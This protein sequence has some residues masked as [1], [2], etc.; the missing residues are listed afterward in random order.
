MAVSVSTATLNEY[1]SIAAKRE[2]AAAAITSGRDAWDIAN[3]TD[4]G[5]FENFQNRVCGP[6]Q[7]AADALIRKGIPGKSFMTI[8]DELSNYARLDLALTGPSYRQSYLAAIGARIPYGAAEAILECYGSVRKVDPQWVFPKGVYSATGALAALGMHRFGR[9]SVAVWDAATYDGALDTTKIIAAPILCH[10]VDA[11]P[12]GT[13]LMSCAI[14]GTGAAKAITV[15]PHA[16]ANGQVMVGE[17]AI[18]SMAS[19]SKAN[20]AATGQFA[21]G[22]WVLLM[23]GSVCEPAKIKTGGI[24]TNTSLE[25]ETALVNTFT[26]AG[27]IWPMFTNITWTSGAIDTGKKIDFYARPDRIIAL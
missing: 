11:T 1:D 16:S 19:T 25:F 4:E 14:Q 26:N 13:P 15:T 5:D 6:A 20:V 8:L 10:T 3:A 9:L 22:E 7:S 17:Q 24:V 27:V 23:E 12:A 21:V 2:A 18:T